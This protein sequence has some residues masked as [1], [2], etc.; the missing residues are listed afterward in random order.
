[1]RLRDMSGKGSHWVMRPAR[2]PTGWRLNAA[3]G[4]P[5]R[6]LDLVPRERRWGAG[7]IRQDA[8]EAAVRKHFVDTNSARIW[9]GR[10]H[11]CRGRGEG[12]SHRPSLAR[13]E[14]GR[15]IFALGLL[16]CLLLLSQ[17]TPSHSAFNALFPAPSS[18][19]PTRPCPLP[20]AS[21]RTPPTSS[22]ACPHSRPLLLHRPSSRV[23]IPV[24]LASS[25]SSRPQRPAPTSPRYAA[26]QPQ[27]RPQTRMFHMR[28]RFLHQRPSRPSY[29]R[30][31]WR[32]QPQVSLPRLRDP[33][34]SPG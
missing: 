10:S 16:R 30:P 8:S 12:C 14:S 31:Y 28:T 9:R 33:L 5:S 13:R 20:D 21:R 23:S 32:A 15:V 29:T 7:P 3:S 4:R 11:R 34:F 27:V 6:R 25:S 19:S 2:T 18:C 26:L 22:P 24:H 17:V 1:M